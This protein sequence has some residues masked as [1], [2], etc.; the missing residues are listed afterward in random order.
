[1]RK[2][3]VRKTTISSSVLSRNENSVRTTTIS[4]SVLSRNE[5]K[6][7]K[8]QK[9]QNETKQNKEQETRKKEQTCP[10]LPFLWL[11]PNKPR[12]VFRG[13]LFPLHGAAK[14]SYYCINT[15]RRSIASTRTKKKDRKKKHCRRKNTVEKTNMTKTF[16]K[17]KQTHRGRV[18]WRY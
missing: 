14:G 18:V 9:T 6:P 8:Q 2:K 1:M 3:R 11:K 17:N 13:C 10:P 5:N 15:C 12:R 4:S 7:H 16:A